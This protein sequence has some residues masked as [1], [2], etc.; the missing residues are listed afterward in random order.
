M[1]LSWHAVA[2]ASTYN[3]YWN[4]EPGVN[5]LNGTAI[6]GVASPYLHTGLDGLPYYYVITAVNGYGESLESEEAMA[7]PPLAPPPP[8]GLTAVQ[9]FMSTTVDLDWHPVQN[10]YDY[11]IYRCHAWSISTPQTGCQPSVSAGCFGPWERIGAN[12][13][14]T[15][16]A[17]WTVSTNSYW[18]YVTARNAFDSSLPS[19]WAGLCVEPTL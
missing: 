13:A 9:R 15:Q 10:V 3:L 19:E 14:D 1:L 11:D 6:T 2:T 5:K 12:V 17:D 18:Y 16:F 8:T 7:T 4:N